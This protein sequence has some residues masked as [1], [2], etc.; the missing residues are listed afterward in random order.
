MRDPESANASP[1]GAASAASQRGEGLA[2]EAQGE[3]SGGEGACPEEP[4]PETPPHP[5][6][7]RRL[8]LS[9]HAGRGDA[10]RRPGVVLWCVVSLAFVIAAAVSAFAL[11]R[12]A[13]N[14]GPLNL[15]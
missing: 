3:R 6:G 1:R 9:P 10:R 7:C 8:G 15:S 11:W 13:E 12:F 5:D 14:L 2:S 4:C